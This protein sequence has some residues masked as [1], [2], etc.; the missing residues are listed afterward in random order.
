MAHAFGVSSKAIRDAITNF[1][2]IPHRLEWIGNINGVNYF[3]DSKATN[4]AAALAAIKSFEKKLIVIM[5]GEDKGHTDFSQLI[6][7]LI[8][9]VKYI[10]TYGQAGEAIKKQLNTSIEVTYLKEFKAAVLQASAQSNPGDSVL[11]SPA[12]TS[13]DQ[14]C[15]Y[16]ERGNTF[17][18]IFNNLELGL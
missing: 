11:L 2:P 6:P 4:L 10:F 12:C 9:R 14:F 3:N 18:N 8:N 16:E 1:A 5:G 17:K 13:F 15:N 7:S